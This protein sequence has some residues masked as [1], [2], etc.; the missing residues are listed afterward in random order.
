MTSAAVFSTV[1][2][3]ALEALQV[4]NRDFGLNLVSGITGMDRGAPDQLLVDLPAFKEINQ[5]AIERIETSKDSV[6]Q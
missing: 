3:V 6:M 2:D 4:S 1:H 5:K